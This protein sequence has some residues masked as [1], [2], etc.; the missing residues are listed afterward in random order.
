[1]ENGALDRFKGMFRRKRSDVKSEKQFLDSLSHR[2]YVGGMWDEIGKLQFDF[3]VADGLM[4]SHCF[5]DVACGSFRGGIHFIRYLEPGNYLGIEKEQQLV[6]KGVEEEIG[7]AIFEEKKPEI[8]ISDSFEFARFSKVPD[9]SLAISLF[10]HLVPDDIILCLA[11]LREFVNPG[12]LFF[13][14]FFD[15]PSADN[16]EE[17]HS[18]IKFAYPRAEMERSGRDN[19]WNAHYIGD[20]KHPRGQLMMKYEAR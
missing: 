13:A 2:E 9:Y 1:M 14:T 4:P 8:V 3:M 16:P 17:S 12:H 6:D 7:E 5:C 20:W 15:E 11:H 19:G 10:T 18:N